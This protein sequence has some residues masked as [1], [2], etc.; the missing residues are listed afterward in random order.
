[1]NSPPIGRLFP[2]GGPADLEAMIGRA[3]EVA[4]Y[5]AFVDGGAH[6]LVAGDRRIGKTTVCRAACAALRERGFLVLSVEVPER[7]TSIDL[8]QMIVDCC[9]AVGAERGLRLF[10]LAR[11]LVENL[12]RDQGLPLDLSALQAEAAARTRREA[13]GLPLSLTADGQRVL[14]FFD[15]L[16]RIADYDDGTELVHDLVDLYAGQ[17]RAMVLADGS[18]QRTLDALLG[19]TVG[20]GKLVVRRDL[21]PRIARGEWEAQLPARFATA[22]HP[23]EQHALTRLLDYGAERAYPTMAAARHAAFTAHAVGG[24]TDMFCVQDGIAAAEKQLADDGL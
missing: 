3:A 17:D 18:E 24:H 20:L 10:G 22:G 4:D 19:S 7:S 6:V 1:M 14:L 5:V 21:S 8:S 15:E 13:L 16:Q 9:L 12:L 23:I 2:A 11:P